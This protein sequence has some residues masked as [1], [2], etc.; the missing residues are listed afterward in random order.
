MATTPRGDDLRTTHGSNIAPL[1][2]SDDVK[3]SYFK[4]IG[5]EDASVAASDFSS[6]WKKDDADGT[7]AV[8]ASRPRVK[9]SIERLKYNKNDDCRFSSNGTKA[10]KKKKCLSF[11]EEVTVVPIPMRHEY[12]NRVRARLWSNALEIQENAVRNAF[13]FAAEG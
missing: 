3:M 8:R 5:I 6:S 7:K 9:C 2:F 12:S 1:V 13:E 10:A 4:A 11:D